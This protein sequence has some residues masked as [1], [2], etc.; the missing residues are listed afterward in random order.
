MNTDQISKSGWSELDDIIKPLL[1]KTLGLPPNAANEYI[2]DNRDDGLMSVPLA[3]EDSDIS[4][5][6]GGFKLLTT[7]DHIV[8]DLAWMLL[9]ENTNYRQKSDKVDIQKF[10]N[11]E[12]H[13][14]S[15][16]KYKSP[17]TRAR[18]TSNRLGIKGLPNEERNIEVTCGNERVVDRR[19]VFRT[20]RLA[21]RKQRTLSL[22]GH[23]HQG[24]TNHC[25][26]KSKSSSHFYRW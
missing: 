6:D 26:A 7:E 16:N 5:I 1:K 2:Y 21:L 17:W 22:R 11:S 24:K 18:Q 9:I 25:I 12:G 23:P 13:E 3:A 4:Q 14:R 10:L 20:A 8:Q 15:S 19:R